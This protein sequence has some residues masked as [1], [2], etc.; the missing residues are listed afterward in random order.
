MSEIIRIAIDLSKG[1]FALHGVNADEEAVLCRQLKR[2]QVLGFFT[3]LSPCLVG[4]EACA[5]AH[6]W[7]REIGALGHEVVLVPPAYV[8]PY[9]KRGR[10][11]D[12]N[13]AAAICEA[14]ARRSVPRV[15]VKTPEQQA[16]LML[17]RARKMLVGQ[18][19]A[20]A[21]MV[22]WPTSILRAR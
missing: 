6:Y 14:M 18:R 19:T 21:S 5:S 1:A 9:V 12:A 15:P 2:G 7:A 22:R 11:N 3:K 20:L 17:H 10:K 4:M 16:V 8:K 13:D